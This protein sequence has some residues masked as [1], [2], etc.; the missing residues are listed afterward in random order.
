[1]GDRRTHIS[2]C[3]GVF[4]RASAGKDKWA[5]QINAISGNDQGVGFNAS[6]SSDIY[7]DNS[8][9]VPS[10]VQVIMCIKY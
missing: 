2:N 1:M 4:Y 7:Q 8:N 10:S 9:V 6:G 5:S 3:K